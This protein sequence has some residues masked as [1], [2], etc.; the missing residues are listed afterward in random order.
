[1]EQCSIDQEKYQ[2]SDFKICKVG[3]GGMSSGDNRVWLDPTLSLNSYRLKAG[4]FFFF[5]FSEIQNLKSF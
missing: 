5:F 3:R 2:V 1:L 4:V